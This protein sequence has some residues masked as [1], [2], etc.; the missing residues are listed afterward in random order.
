M[1][2][3]HIV[4]ECA[5]KRTSRVMQVES[6]FDVPASEKTRL[7]WDVNLPIDDKEWN[8]G[9][10]VGPSGSGKTVIARELFNDS[11]IESFN[12]DSSAIIDNFPNIGIKNIVGNLTSV[13]F[14]SPP[15]WT[16]PFGVLSNGEKFRATIARAL[17]EDRD[18]VVID[19]Y[20][21][22]VDRQV[23]KVGSHAIQK[24]VRR[25]KK[26][27][28]AVSCHYDILEWLQPDWVY[29]PHA[30]EFSWRLLHRRPEIKFNIYKIDKSSWSVF[31]K[32]HYMSAD[33]HPAARCFGGFIENECVA[34]AAYLHVPHPRTKNIKRLH[35]LVVL[36]DYQGIGA[37]GILNDWI[38]LMLYENGYRFRVVSAHPAM[39][40]YLK[41]SKRWRW[42]DRGRRKRLTVGPNSKMIL[43]H[44]M[45]Q[46]PRRLNLSS[47]EYTPSKESK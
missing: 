33:L 3:A 37:G 39:L 25:N 18:V 11:I 43:M 45:H 42:C 30:N 32:H 10:I 38:G 17:S 6:M 9:L 15:S 36:P 14:G 47:F 27:F 7:T 21:S 44:L 41:R 34:F 8:V 22:V 40:S 29:Q 24:T 19:E 35:R 1:P 26:K 4:R 13:G 16:R 12:W 20:T 31:K 28:V 2:S 23:A 5:T 46:N